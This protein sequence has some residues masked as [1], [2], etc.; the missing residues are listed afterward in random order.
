MNKFC[1][2]CKYQY[3]DRCGADGSVRHIDP[4]S[5]RTLYESTVAMRANKDMC[6]PGGIWFE[7]RPPVVRWWKEPKLF[8][9]KLWS[10]TPT[11]K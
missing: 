8:G 10:A 9:R 7:K 5:G 6:G 2:N 3:N 4:V 1:V 11:I